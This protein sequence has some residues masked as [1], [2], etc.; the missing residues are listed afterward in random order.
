MLTPNDKSELISEIWKILPFVSWISSLLLITAV[1]S[2]SFH[3]TAEQC[4]FTRGFLFFILRL[5]VNKRI[6]VCVRTH[7]VFGGGIAADVAVDASGVYVVSSGDVFF[8]LV[9]TVGQ[10]YLLNN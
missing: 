1:V 9:V 4:F 2:D 7:E 3:R 8:Y 5:L 10:T 6:A